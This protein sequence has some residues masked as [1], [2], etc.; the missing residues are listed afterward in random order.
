[1][2]KGTFFHYSKAYTYTLIKMHSVKIKPNCSKLK[3]LH[4]NEW[5]YDKIWHDGIIY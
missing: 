1:M 5:S 3:T 4:V 2:K